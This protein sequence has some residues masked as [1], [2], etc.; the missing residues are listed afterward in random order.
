MFID[1]C[2]EIQ[3]R[4]VGVAGGGTAQRIRA[5]WGKIFPDNH[6]FMLLEP[7]LEQ[8]HLGKKWGSSSQ[9]KVWFFLCLPQGILVTWKLLMA[10][11]SSVCRHLLEKALISSPCHSVEH[12]S[13]PIY[14]WENWASERQQVPSSEPKS[15]SKLCLSSS[16]SFP[17]PPHMIKMI[18]FRESTNLIH[19]KITVKV[20]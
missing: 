19:S 14:R 13:Q 18:F 10:V 1:S 2:S 17:K 16:G 7:W 8:Q 20:N 4:R 3:A 6:Q 12:V 15:S 5:H 11:T 9:E